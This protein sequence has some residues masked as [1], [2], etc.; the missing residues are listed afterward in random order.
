MQRYYFGN[1]S[2][3][4]K[5]II[6]ARGFKRAARK[7]LKSDPPGKRIIFSLHHVEIFF[8]SCLDEDAK[9]DRKPHYCCLFFLYSNFSSNM[10]SLNK[11]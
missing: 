1:E 3:Q 6:L 11:C 10:R 2:K 8:L 4:S 7:V 5:D 9:T